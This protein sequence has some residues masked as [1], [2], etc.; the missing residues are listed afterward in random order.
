[1]RYSGNFSAFDFQPRYSLQGRAC[2]LISN[3]IKVITNYVAPQPVRLSTF[4]RDA[5]F[6]IQLVTRSTTSSQT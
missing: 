2:H 3:F 6:C 4:N 1:M 5:F